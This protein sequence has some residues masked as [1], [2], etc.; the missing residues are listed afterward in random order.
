MQQT[1]NLNHTHPQAILCFSKNN[2][3]LEDLPPLNLHELYTLSKK[4]P[5]IPPFFR[6]KL[7]LIG[8]DKTGSRSIAKARIKVLPNAELNI[9]E[10]AY[11]KN[12]NE[13]LI[14]GLKQ[15][16]TTLKNQLEF[17]VLFRIISFKIC[18]IAYAK[19]GLTI[20]KAHTDTQSG[21][22]STL[23]HP[24]PLKRSLDGNNVK[25][26]RFYEECHIAAIPAI[27]NSHP[28]L[29]LI[30]ED[31]K[32]LE[33]NEVLQKYS[34]PEGQKPFLELLKTFAT[35]KDD[36]LIESTA[37]FLTTNNLASDKAAH[38]VC[39]KIIESEQ[40]KELSKKIFL[41]YP[42][43]VKKCF[44]E[45]GSTYFNQKAYKSTQIEEAKERIKKHY[46]EITGEDFFKLYNNRSE[47]KVVER[48]FKKAPSMTCVLKLILAAREANL[49][50]LQNLMNFIKFEFP[51]ETPLRSFIFENLGANLE[52]IK[53]GIY[54]HI[55][56]LNSLAGTMLSQTVSMGLE[57]N[58]GIDNSTDNLCLTVVPQLLTNF[59]FRQNVNE[60]DLNNAIEEYKQ[61]LIDT[62]SEYAKKANGN[63]S[64]LPP[65]LEE[66]IE[67]IPLPDSDMQSIFNELNKDSSLY[68][69]VN[70]GLS[71]LGHLSDTD[72][73]QIKIRD[74]L[75]FM[76][77]ENSIQ[78]KINQLE[79]AINI[80]SPDV[81][82]VR[83]LNIYKF[84]LNN[85]NDIRSKIDNLKIP[86]ETLN[87]EIQTSPYGSMHNFIVRY[88]ASIAEYCS[89]VTQDSD[90]S[91]FE[92][93]LLGKNLTL[94]DSREVVK[95]V[96]NF[97]LCEGKGNQFCW[98]RV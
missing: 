52:Q 87:K 5:P 86:E 30:A 82:H 59:S 36:E 50:E 31:L 55:L 48:D 51:E 83:L 95:P 26:L 96:V 88:E 45:M 47:K 75:S 34:I 46:F 58:K 98:E 54:N 13:D 16:T 44:F 14:L 61:I 8:P 20:K 9:R 38:R 2:H 79:E 91:D 17:A 67:N 15:R 71:Y 19:M 27:K 80:D 77:D 33:V 10:G 72:Q 41:L 18:L 57:I 76:T 97:L 74:V 62:Y 89:K 32:N 39:K 11:C 60:V 56:P 42:Y 6:E 70:I 43:I 93:A 28:Q 68:D 66:V 29:N 53:S 40:T 25:D 65:Q 84:F 23:N 21:N 73:Y 24:H 37:N 12:P 69:L 63:T 49:N 92:R 1:T 81:E 35:K 90:A 78:V 7:H 4:T 64:A 85:L 22:Y 94:D 3:L